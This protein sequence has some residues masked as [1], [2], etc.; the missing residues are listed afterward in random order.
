M[1]GTDLIARVLLAALALGAI[2]WLALSFRNAVLLDDAFDVAATPGVPPER[3]DDAL[4]LT[5][6]G[7]TLNP[8]RAHVWRLRAVLQRRS[9]RPDLA[10]ETMK[11]STRSEPENAD[12][13]AEL[14]QL[15]RDIDPELSAEARERWAALDPV[16]ARRLRDR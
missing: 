2:A 12:A 7:E 3:I 6:R 11:R 14:A 1:A 8:D 9:G 4:D 13:W 15:T 5:E 16:A 10:I